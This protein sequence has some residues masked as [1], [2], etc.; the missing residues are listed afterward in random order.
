MRRWNPKKYWL[1]ARRLIRLA[2]ISMQSMVLFLH[3]SGKEET[4][5]KSI[6]PVTY[7]YNSERL[8]NLFIEKAHERLDERRKRSS[9]YCT[10]LLIFG[11]PFTIS[12]ILNASM[13]ITEC[14]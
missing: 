13:R 8:I 5:I 7:L 14:Q 3:F 12:Q 11:M 9:G 10:A 6:I 4:T 1:I 2:L